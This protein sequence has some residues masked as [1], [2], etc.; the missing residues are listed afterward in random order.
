[1]IVHRDGLAELRVSNKWLQ[2][3]V[4][5]QRGEVAN[6]SE[7]NMSKS[8]NGESKNELQSLYEIVAKAVMK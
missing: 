3:V 4:C 7:K 1:M 8:Q 2:R 5:M 6:E